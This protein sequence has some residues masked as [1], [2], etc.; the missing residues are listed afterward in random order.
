MQGTVYVKIWIILRGEVDKAS[1]DIQCGYRR[2]KQRMQVE[3]WKI[4]KQED[5]K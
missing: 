3:P 5:G 4:F 2:E 1:N